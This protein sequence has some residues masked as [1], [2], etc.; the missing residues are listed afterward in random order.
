VLGI[1]GAGA[2]FSI[3][4]DSHGVGAPVAGKANAGSVRKE[5][6]RLAYYEVL[7]TNVTN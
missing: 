4:P 2:S 1:N 6:G 7:Y 3:K 5:Q